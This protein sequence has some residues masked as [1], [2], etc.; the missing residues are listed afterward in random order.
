M[1]WLQ[2][3][4]SAASERSPILVVIGGIGP[5]EMAEEVKMKRVL[6]IVLAVAVIGSAV[7]AG[8][9]AA[10]PFGCG[11]YPADGCLK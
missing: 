3:R 5:P 11:L 8:S 10:R 9:A 4:Y 2:G 7:A 6:A 1:A